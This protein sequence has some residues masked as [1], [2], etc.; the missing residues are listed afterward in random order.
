MAYG[1][2]D[3][4]ISEALVVGASGIGFDRR[5]PTHET[6][7]PTDDRV[8]CLVVCGVL[9]RVGAH[10]GGHFGDAVL[11]KGGMLRGVATKMWGRDEVETLARL[12]A[13]N[14]PIHRISSRM[15]SA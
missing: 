4:R 14:R 2:F 11:A 15:R 1:I 12:D 3:A 6:M 10:R 9:A 13:W 7:H 8:R 5:F